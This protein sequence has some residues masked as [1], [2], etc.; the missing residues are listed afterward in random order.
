MFLHRMREFRQAAYKC[1]CKASDATFELMD[2]I[3][4]T[5]NAYSAGGFIFM[6]S[7]M[8]SARFANVANGQVC[9]KHYKIQKSNEIN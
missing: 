3:L 9:M 8:P 4:L 6:P 7:V 2:S 1:L 5:R